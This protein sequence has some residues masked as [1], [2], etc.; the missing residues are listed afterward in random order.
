MADIRGFR[1]RASDAR[2]KTV[3]YSLPYTIAAMKILK[4]PAVRL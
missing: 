4:N 2:G 1:C 3:D